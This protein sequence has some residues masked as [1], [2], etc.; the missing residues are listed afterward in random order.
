MEE[1]YNRLK[2]GERLRNKRKKIGWSQER[3][4]EMMNLSAKYYADIERGTCGMSIETLITLS[5]V[6]QMSA[7]MI[8]FGEESSTRFIDYKVEN[9]REKVRTGGCPSNC[10]YILARMAREGEGGDGAGSKNGKGR[11]DAGSKGNV[12][13]DGAGSRPD[14]PSKSYCS[15]ICPLGEDYDTCNKTFLARSHADMKVFFN[16]V[17]TGAVLEVLDNSRDIVRDHLMSLLKNELEF[18]EKL[19]PTVVANRGRRKASDKRE[20]EAEG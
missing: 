14:T 16:N 2:T 19:S 6:Y 7:D 5:K 17:E 3:A 1:L 9:A 11:D 15:D 4:A 18:S 8:L 20:G 10:S 13:V 12:Y